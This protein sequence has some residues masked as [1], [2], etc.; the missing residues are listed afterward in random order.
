[1][2]KEVWF[3]S[4]DEVQPLDVSALDGVVGD[5]DGQS[6]RCHTER[7]LSYVVPEVVGPPSTEMAAARRTMQR[8]ARSYYDTDNGVDKVLR[9]YSFWFV[10]R[11]QSSPEL[12]RE[13]P[14]LLAIIF[15]S[16]FEYIRG[17]VLEIMNTF[18]SRYS[19]S[20]FGNEQVGQSGDASRRHEEL[21]E[22]VQAWKRKL[23]QAVSPRQLVTILRDMSIWAVS[24][25]VRQYAQ[26]KLKRFAYGELY[27]HCQYSWKVEAG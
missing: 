22:E 12:F 3:D 1:M 26:L 23:A 2:A 8:L 27:P 13:H 10:R 19:G 7:M 9:G 25:E 14:F 11:V 5:V 15:A 6:V 17:K 20:D 21:I 24:E 4:L 18:V 16:E